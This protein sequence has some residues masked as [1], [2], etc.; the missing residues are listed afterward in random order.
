MNLILGFTGGI[1]RATAKALSEKN[2][3]MV[4]LVRDI[5][6]AERYAIGLKG[7]TFIEGDASSP[8]D[9]E[10]AMV[11]V[12]HLFYCI[13]VPY[14]QWEEKARQLLKISVD[15]CVLHKA[16]LVF[17]GNVYVYGRPQFNP[18]TEAHPQFP[19]SRK[20][21][22]RQEM[23]EM[24]F[25]A[26]KNSGLRYTIIRMPDFYGPYVINGFSENIF[27]NA[28]KGKKLS[29]AGN[30]KIPT[31]FIFIEDAGIAMA[32]AG[33]DPKADGYMF[34]VPGSHE[35]TAKAVFAEIG[36][37]VGK[38]LK[39]G[40][41]NNDLL[42]GFAGLFNPIIKEFRE[43]LYL[44]QVKLILSGNFYKGFFGLLPAT[45]YSEGIRKTLDWAKEFYNL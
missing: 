35:T 13:N 12:D 17:P 2:Q 11:N 27:I 21:R 26:A 24:I 39:V 42:I 14:P 41:I 43:M 33:L 15:A 29:W 34:N 37:A 9:L 31:E 7:V 1:G 40:S 36:K 19:N 6:K 18:V 20:G 23:E 4:A 16:K 8:A 22:I 28:I 38:K 5:K 32:T 44:K 25:N 30:L 3:P 10:R 45:P